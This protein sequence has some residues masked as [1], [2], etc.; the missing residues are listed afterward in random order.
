M[1]SLLVLSL[2]LLSSGGRGIGRVAQGGT[3]HEGHVSDSP[4]LDLD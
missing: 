3:K 2:L 1:L 4:S